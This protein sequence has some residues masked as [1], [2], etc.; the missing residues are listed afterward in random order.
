MRRTVKRVD[1]KWVYEEPK[2]KSSRRRLELPPGTVRALAGLGRDGELVFTNGFGEPVNIYTV[3]EHHFKPALE[4]A[5]LPKEVRLYDLRHT[6]ATLLLSAGVHPKIVS[7]RLGHSTIHI[8]LDI[9]SHVLPHMQKETAAKL[10]AILFT[11][12]VTDEPR[13]YN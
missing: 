7:E 12:A 9:Y 4:R 3:I 6:H 1:G 8:T 5:G 13:A 10:E 11:P 2:T